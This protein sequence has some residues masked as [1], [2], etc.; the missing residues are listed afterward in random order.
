LITS[1]SQVVVVEVVAVVDVVVVEVVVVEVVVVEVVV[2]VV[3]VVVVEVVTV[4]VV[5]VVNVVVSS[6]PKETFDSIV[7]EYFL[8]LPW[9]NHS[10]NM[11][12]KTIPDTNAP[13]V[14]PTQQPLEVDNDKMS[15]KRLR[16]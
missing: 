4:V 12:A 2:V 16:F 14:K 5:T 13:M 8:D 6:V 9:R 3:V 1:Y 15:L 10:I 7:W 11:M